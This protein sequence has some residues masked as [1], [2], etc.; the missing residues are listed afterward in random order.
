MSEYLDGEV[1][2]W[3]RRRMEGHL[4]ECNECRR[5]LA[6]LRAVLRGLHGL[7]APDSPD[8]A[9]TA[10]AVRLRIGAGPR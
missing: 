2:S 5:L 6:G 9:H 4:V 8:P 10:A 3:R 7:G 1:S